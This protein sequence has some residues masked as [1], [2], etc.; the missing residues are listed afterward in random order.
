MNDRS[1]MTAV[2]RRYLSLA[3]LQVVA[4][5]VGLGWLVLFNLQAFRY[6]V[7][8]SQRTRERIDA[9]WSIVVM[10]KVQRGT[11]SRKQAIE[12]LHEQGQSLQRID[13]RGASLPAMELPGANLRMAVLTN[14]ALEKANLRSADLWRASLS[15]AAL[16][17][18]TLRNS[19]LKGANLAGARLDKA[20]LRGARPRPGE[21]HPGKPHG[22]RSARRQGD[23][24]ATGGRLRRSANP[25]ANRQH[26]APPGAVAPTLRGKQ[27]NGAQAKQASKRLAISGGTA[28]I[29]AMSDRSDFDL[30]PILPWASGGMFALIGFFALLIS[31]ARPA[32]R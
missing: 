15:G 20:D 28:I 6:V 32:A 8:E 4:L 23:R 9:M 27:V 3:P 17:G 10:P 5:L 18:A 14:A 22:R 24:S 13:L 25:A 11:V 21:P 12:Y 26:G 16:S 7:T 19:R 31:V 29:L 2:L 30:T 1:V